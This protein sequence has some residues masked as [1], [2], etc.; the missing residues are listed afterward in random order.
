MTDLQLYDGTSA[1]PVVTLNY[2]NAHGTGSISVATY[3]DP[4]VSAGTNQPIFYCT[5]LWHDNYLGSTYTI[6]Q[7]PSMAFGISTFADVDNR[8]GWL[9]TQD[10]SSVD[11]RAAVQL[12]VW[13]TVDHVRNTQPTGFSF[14]GGDFTLRSDYNHLISFAGYN[15]GV[16]YSATF[17]QATHDASNTLYQDLIS[18]SGSGGHIQA[19]IPEP[20]GFVLAGIGILGLIGAGHLSKRGR[21]SVASGQ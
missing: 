11:A 8:L 9:L 20:S 6:T 5:D 17:W 10:Q 14:T 1:S 19:T 21:W 7:V 18:A 12:A 15:P 2:T 3:A 4:Q 16:N 13:Y